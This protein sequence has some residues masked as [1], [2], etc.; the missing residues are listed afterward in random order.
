ML[1]GRWEGPVGGLWTYLSVPD[2]CGNHKK[3]VDFIMLSAS[4][5]PGEALEG[6]W[7]LAGRL[8]VLPEAAIR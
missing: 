2:S 8:R 4:E 5:G 1:G 6:P 3:T 7:G